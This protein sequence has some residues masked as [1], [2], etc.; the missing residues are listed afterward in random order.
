MSVLMLGQNLVLGARWSG[1]RARAHARQN[2][3][4][5]CLCSLPSTNCSSIAHHCIYVISY[6]EIKGLLK[7]KSITFLSLNFYQIYLTL[8]HIHLELNF[9]LYFKTQIIY[10]ENWF[11]SK[12]M[13]SRRFNFFEEKPYFNIDRCTAT[14]DAPQEIFRDSFSA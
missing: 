11:V 13:S 2:W 10:D 3:S 12:R 6:I 9:F 4:A 5:Q 8:I 1:A 7:L 14:S